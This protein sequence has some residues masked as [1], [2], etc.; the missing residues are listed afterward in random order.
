[1]QLSVR[2]FKDE[3]RKHL[4]F[5]VERFAVAEAAAG[6]EKSQQCGSL[7]VSIRPTTIPS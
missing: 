5:A 2:S 3:V 1:M 7:R 6:A 4:L